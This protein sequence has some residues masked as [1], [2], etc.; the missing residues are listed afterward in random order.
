MR[1]DATVNAAHAIAREAPA[2]GK[3]VAVIPKGAPA[4]VLAE[5]GGFALVQFKDPKKPDTDLVGWT[6][7]DAFDAAPAVSGAAPEATAKCKAAER[8]L[9][10][11]RGGKVEVACVRTCNP[12]GDGKECAKGTACATA[13]WA[14]GQKDLTHDSIFF[15]DKIPDV[16]CAPGDTK[17]HVKYPS[18]E[19]D[20]DC[21][22]ICASDASMP[23]D[24]DAKCS[25]GFICGAVGSD[26][27]APAKKLSYCVKGARASACAAGT[28]I[29]MVRNGAGVES[30]QCQRICVEAG[31]GK[32]PA[33]GDK[34]CPAGS[35]CGGSGFDLSAGPS[36]MNTGVSFCVPGKRA[37]SP[38][39]AAPT[40]GAGQHYDA[41]SKTCR[42]YGDCPKGYRWNE[43]M[44]SCVDDGS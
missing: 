25:K 31:S 29:V 1:R 42:A 26:P 4:T 39:A 35:Y 17:L 37:G 18:G 44:K 8:P 34:V 40:C 7:S 27:K 5:R 33:E 9:Q 23:A 20:D 6:S 32:D 22:T 14:V 30:E 3:V 38:P 43:P 13:G 2:R 24:G 19:E 11:A 10:V 41:I 36:L 12:E 15:C 28:K 21:E 16:P